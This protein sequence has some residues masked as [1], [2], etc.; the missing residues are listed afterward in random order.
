MKSSS[1]LPHHHFVSPIANSMTTKLSALSLT[2]V[3]AIAPTMAAQASMSED[4]IRKIGEEIGRL[5]GEQVGRDVGK[6][7]AEATMAQIKA[8]IDPEDIDFSGSGSNMT[9]ALTRSSDTDSDA[10][11]DSSSDDWD[12]GT[13]EHAGQ[14]AGEHPG[15]SADDEH[16]SDAAEEHAGNA[17]KE[18][19]GSA[20]HEQA[21]SDSDDYDYR[22]D[23]S[24]NEHAGAA[25][26]EHSD[27]SASEHAGSAAHE[28]AG[29]AANEHPG[30][31]AEENDEGPDGLPSASEVEKQYAHAVTIKPW[32]I[33]PGGNLRENLALEFAGSLQK[34]DKSIALALKFSGALAN[35][36]DVDN[37]VQ[38]LD[39]DGNKKNGKWTLAKNPA[40][41]YF[42][43]LPSGRYTVVVGSKLKD[44]EGKSLRNPVQGP[45]YLQSE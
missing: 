11:L 33:V 45:V 37:N 15:A 12:N 9:A 23:N 29:A 2:A 21:S 3:L 31:S 1:V 20:A 16:P 6:T 38:V 8:G 27:D 42:D 44:K 22:D 4:E 36:S 26:E 30:A 34:S 24:A 35:A 41:V 19:A 14:S 7:V 18:H 25:A 40:V 10:G 5:V 43:K 39:I 32:W 28:H 13:D 17:A